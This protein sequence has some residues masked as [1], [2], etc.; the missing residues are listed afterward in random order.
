MVQ[1]NSSLPLALNMTLYSD[2]SYIYSYSGAITLELEDT[3][4]FQ[5]A[6]ETNGSFAADLLLQ[7]KSCWTTESTDPED[8][9][10]G[11]LLQDGYL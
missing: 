4:F 8:P 2:E 11:V 7:V 5:V 1:F 10:Q 3:L 9:T 6:L